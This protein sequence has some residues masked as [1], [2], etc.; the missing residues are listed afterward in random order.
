MWKWQNVY[1]CS[2]FILLHY[3]MRRSHN[4]FSH[5]LI[6]SLIEVAET[7]NQEDVNEF[8]TFAIE[9]FHAHI[10]LIDDTLPIADLLQ[11]QRVLMTGTKILTLF[12][13]SIVQ[14]RLPLGSR[15]VF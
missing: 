5:C 1:L 6:N 14:K 8:L 9:A 2:T 7:C 13:T 12:N 11:R 15:Q 3:L 4:R 10:D